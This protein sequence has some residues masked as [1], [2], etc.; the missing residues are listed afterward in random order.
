[1]L[2]FRIC[3]ATCWILDSSQSMNK[4]IAFAASAFS[5]KQFLVQVRDDPIW[6]ADGIFHGAD[7]KRCK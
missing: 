6:R 5:L 7:K 3:Q 2:V 4:C 1:M